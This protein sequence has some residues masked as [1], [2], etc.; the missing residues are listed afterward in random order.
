[1]NRSLSLNRFIAPTQ[2][3]AAG[4]SQLVQATQVTREPYRQPGRPQPPTAIDFGLDLN[5]DEDL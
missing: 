4:L 1:M 3:P 5:D 2:S